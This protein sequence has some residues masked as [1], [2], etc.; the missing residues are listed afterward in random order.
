[1]PGRRRRGR[2]A[3]RVTLRVAFAVAG[4]TVLAAGPVLAWSP[5]V[6]ID[7]SLFAAA[8][9][10]PGAGPEAGAEA[11]PETPDRRRREIDIGSPPAD[12][13]TGEGRLLDRP[14]GVPDDATL[15][16]AG[17]VV[18]DI[19]IHAQDI[20]DPSDP[21]E[22]RVLYRFANR[23]HRSTRP[24]VIEN[25]LL[26]RSGD[27][28]SRRVLEESERLL[29]ATRYLY[30]AQIRPIRYRDNRVDLEVI[31]RDVWTLTAGIGVSRSGG[32][33]TT[34]FKIEDTNFLGTGRD[35]A[36]EQESNVDRDVQLVKYRD[37]AV[38]GS[39]T[40]FE[41][42]LGENSDG[43]FR[44]L[45]IERPFFSLD[46]RRAAGLFAIDDDRVDPLYF[47]G[48]ITDKFRVQ[49][50]FGEVYL[51]ISEG[52]GDGIDDPSGDRGANRWIAG[53]TYD[54]H[55]FEPA[56]GEPLPS[57]L[58]EDRTLAYPWVGYQWVEDAYL[59]VSDVDQLRRTE[60]LYVGRS[61]SARLGYSPEELSDDR[62]RAVF[63][64]AFESG[65]KP[66]SGKLLLLS[67]ELG[68]R[69]ADGSAENMLLGVSAR[70][71]QRTFKR[72][73]FYATLA[74]AYADDLDEDN[75]LLLGGDTGLRGY[76][77]RY[78]VGDR[79][80]LLTLEQRFYTDRHLFRLLHVGG[81]VFVDVGRAWYEAG[82]HPRVL[83]GSV[84]YDTGTLSDVGFGLRLGS[85]RSG[86]G[87]MI[88]LDVAFPLNGDSSIE[89]VQWLVS[90]KET[91]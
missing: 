14:P 80:V 78:Q 30:D 62:D 32:E 70:Y 91:F 21:A 50:T 84:D 44:R 54:R 47:G 85:S 34:R 68:G 57:V 77:L 38:A 45:E 37:L 81:A 88:H 2:P 17:A 8:E 53:F 29:R 66:G 15:E 61:F 73:L 46:T 5:P 41:M 55:R 72:H 89:D 22:D 60:D 63:A 52:L 19:V 25:L 56:V 1:M 71:F 4:W 83:K 36:I 90:T 86:Q 20:F 31:T 79:R 76:P 10:V 26:V 87:S 75:Q 51:G 35:V 3:G 65:F 69:W 42:W 24:R 28:Y 6:P 82:V 64:A 49:R 33:N 23:L 48:G 11:T 9:E 39:R 43:S 58:P 18:G 74:A 40:S 7:A 16:A 67:G 59:E 12:V 27:P 13:S